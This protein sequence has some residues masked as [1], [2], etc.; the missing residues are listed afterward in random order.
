MESDNTVQYYLI[1]TNVLYDS[2]KFRYSLNHIQME[3]FQDQIKD[4]EIKDKLLNNNNNKYID[5]KQ[6][7]L[8][9]LRL[10]ENISD[11]KQ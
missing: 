3:T 6:K 11:I 4:K 9:F 7:L 2:N 5:E 1:S 8:Y 10:L